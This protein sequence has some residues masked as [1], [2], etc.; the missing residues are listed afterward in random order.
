MAAIEEALEPGDE[1][2]L[3]GLIIPLGASYDFI[4]IDTPA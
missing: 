3:S 2:R 4:L 1:T